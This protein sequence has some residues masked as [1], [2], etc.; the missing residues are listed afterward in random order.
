MKTISIALVLSALIIGSCVAPAMALQPTVGYTVYLDFYSCWPCSLD[1]V[2]VSLY[3]QAGRLVASATS[4]YGAEVA[5]SFR[6][7]D[8]IYSLTA[9]AHARA[10]LGSCGSCYTWFVRGTSTKNVGT[11][12]YY[13]ISV[14][15]R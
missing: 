1:S 12:G 9:S 2:G 10:S 8:P 11:S 4:P 5:V 13:W 14:L 7:S 3:D 6:T 15:M